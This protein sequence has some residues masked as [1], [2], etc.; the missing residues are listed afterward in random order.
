MQ[1][2]F[3]Q[4]R[5][6]SVDRPGNYAACNPLFFAINRAMRSLSYAAAIGGDLE[7]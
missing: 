4:V 6:P 3:D 7:C 5:I 1:G 2:V